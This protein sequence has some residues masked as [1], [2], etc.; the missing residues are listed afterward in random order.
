MDTR[1]VIA[2]IIVRVVL[3]VLV[4]VRYSYK[5]HTVHYFGFLFTGF[6]GIIGCPCTQYID[7]Y[8]VIRAGIL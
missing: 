5:P 3:V 7:L 1:H 6:H 8:S 2:I 4:V